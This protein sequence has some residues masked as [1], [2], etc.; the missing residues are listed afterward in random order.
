MSQEVVNFAVPVGLNWK[1]QSFGSAVTV[2]GH[3]V[4]RLVE[5]RIGGF[6]QRLEQ[7][8]VGQDGEQQGL[9]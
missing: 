6:R 7:R 5:R 1:L 8:E 4:L 3:F 9:P 2:A